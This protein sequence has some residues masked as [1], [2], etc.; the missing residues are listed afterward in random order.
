MIRFGSR[1]DV[2]IPEG[3]GFTA[4]LN[5]KV[6]AGETILAM[7]NEK[8]RKDPI[9]ETPDLN[10]GANGDHADLGDKNGAKYS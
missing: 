9:K 6:K 4:R 2:I 7:R 5:D 1:V 10:T 8:M 3:Y